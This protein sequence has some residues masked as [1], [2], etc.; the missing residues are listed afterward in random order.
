[1]REAAGL[2]LVTIIAWEGLI[3]RMDI[4]AGQ[5]VLIQG[6]AGGVGHLAIQLARAALIF[7]TGSETNRGI[8]ERFGATFIDRREP[9]ADHVGRLKDGHGFDRVYDTAGGAALDA[10]FEAVRRFG[11]VVSSLGWRARWRHSH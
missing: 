3:D 7:T 4:S 6:G 9:V 5:R 1:M 10:S 8:I 11:H 2:P